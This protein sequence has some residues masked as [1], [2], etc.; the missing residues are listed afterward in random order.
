MSKF[1]ILWIDDSDKK[2]KKERLLVK[3][4]IES[5]DL[6]PDIKF[7]SDISKS[8]LE[9]KDGT[10]NKAL[11]AR[12]YDLLVIDYWLSKDV[13]GSTIITEVRNKKH[14][15]TD[16][17]FYSSSKEDLTN[18]VKSSYESASAFDYFDGVYVAP[19]QEEWFLQKIQFVIQKIINSWFSPNAIRGV[20]LD[21][22]SKIETI[23]CDLVGK[24]YKPY[25]PEI[26]NFIKTKRI[27]IQSDVEKKW[28]LLD[29][30]S[31]PVVE[32]ISNQDKYNWN[33][34]KQLFDI[35]LER[36]AVEIDD[37]TSKAMDGLF[38]RRNM[39]F[40]HNK[41]I[42]KDGVIEIV[43]NGKIKRY[44]DAKIAK[45]RHDIYIIEKYFESLG[46]N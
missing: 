15:Y 10:L 12:D 16:I 19:M 21:K 30:A 20:I 2:C 40:A 1:K 46:F 43:V 6:T 5:L 11:S 14:I 26:K 39:Y 3:A 7:I 23:V 37:E 18:A 35:L 42:L 24:M 34:K 38:I 33:L 32:I 17:V 41:A 45:I 13:L 29:E 8:S 28:Q 9:N 36:G 31:D 44:D 22:T 27:N 25:L 4:F